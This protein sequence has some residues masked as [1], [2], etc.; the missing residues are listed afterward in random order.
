MKIIA[1]GIELTGQAAACSEFPL[2]LGW[3]TFAGPL[4]VRHR[5]IICDLH[6]RIIF[7]TLDVAFGAFRMTPVRAFLIT[8]PYVMVVQG[9][10][11]GCRSE[12]SRTRDEIFGKR[13][14]VLCG[15]GC[16]FG[17]CYV[18]SCGDE[19]S[20]LFVSQFRSIHPEPVDINPMDGRC[21]ASHAG[22][23]TKRLAFN[24]TAHRELATWNPYHSSRSCTWHRR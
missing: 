23:A 18:A 15:G 6:D 10:R 12:H 3:Q 22:H 16:A 7:S 20:K 5:V 13:A 19:F 4:C 1:P 21:I 8:P 24:R 14:G 2:G 9:N 11:S 17:N